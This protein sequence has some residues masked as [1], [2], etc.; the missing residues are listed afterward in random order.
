MVRYI[1]KLGRAGEVPRENQ[2]DK[3]TNKALFRGTSSESD[4]LGHVMGL[5]RQGVLL[6]SFRGGFGCGV[7]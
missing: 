1:W 3:E 4:V 7:E 6:G 2:L 5:L